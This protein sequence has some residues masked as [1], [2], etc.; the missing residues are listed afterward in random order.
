MNAKTNGLG[1]TD[2]G[3]MV[4]VN[5]G[6]HIPNLRTKAMDFLEASLPYFFFPYVCVGINALHSPHF[7]IHFASSTLLFFR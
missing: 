1:R 7:I 4:G 3:W 5:G 6:A 2:D